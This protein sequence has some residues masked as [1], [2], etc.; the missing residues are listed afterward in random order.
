M[1]N[2]LTNNF[3]PN[4]NDIIYQIIKTTYG[5]KIINSVLLMIFS[6]IVKNIIYT[7]LAFLIL[8][9][10]IYIDFFTQ[11]FLSICICSQNDKINYYVEQYESRLYGITRY[12]INNWSIERV[13]KYK[14]P[15]IL[16]VL[17]SG[18]I[19]LSIVDVATLKIYILQYM[20]CHFCMDIK[21]NDDHFIRRRLK[22]EK[23]KFFISNHCQGEY[24]VINKQKIEKIPRNISSEFE[25]IDVK[26]DG[27][28]ILE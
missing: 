6:M 20:F 28:E 25:L 16:G 22:L 18:Y 3:I 21:D 12:L 23:K 15:A 26:E 24:I 10:N 4:T 27:F 11:C 5:K 7:F 19:Y 13:I 9:N 1:F 14:T 17:G 2:T 8:I